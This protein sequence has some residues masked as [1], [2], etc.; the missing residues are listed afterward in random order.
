MPGVQFSTSGTPVMSDQ[1]WSEPE[2]M[3]PTS[4]PSTLFVNNETTVKSEMLSIVSTTLSSVISST[5]ESSVLTGKF[6]VF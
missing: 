3:L 5:T 2:E 1:N 6:L 4:V